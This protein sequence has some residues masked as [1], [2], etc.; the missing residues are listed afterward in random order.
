MFR[1][2]VAIERQPRS[3]K[4]QAAQKTAGV[5]SANWIQRDRSLLPRA[6]RPGKGS[7]C[8]IASAATG[9]ASAVAIR[10]RRAM[11]ASS[12]RSAASVSAEAVS[13]SSGMP[14]LM[15]S[16]GCGSVTS[17]CIGQT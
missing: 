9:R 12:R 7:R 14:H 2:R 13:A 3:M 11:A 4:G 5:A 17:G 15:Q 8:D 10:R 16:P 1:L 6:R